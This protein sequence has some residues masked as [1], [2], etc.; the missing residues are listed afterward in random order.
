MAKFSCMTSLVASF[1]QKQFFF[2]GRSRFF[3]SFLYLFF[4]IKSQPRLAE[5]VAAMVT[6]KIS[7]EEPQLKRMN[8][9]IFVK[10]RDC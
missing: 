3:F 9:F 2:C 1:W 8:V 10:K 7:C 5:A 4:F 6:K